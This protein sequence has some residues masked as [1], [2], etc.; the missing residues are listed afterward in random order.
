MCFQQLRNDLQRRLLMIS[1]SS[2]MLQ[3]GPEAI[4]YMPCTSLA[5]DGHRKY[6][7]LL[8]IL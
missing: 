8:A 6:P 2:F 4:Y 1:V 5:D 7:Y 3:L